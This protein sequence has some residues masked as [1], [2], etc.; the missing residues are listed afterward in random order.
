[1]KIRF[2]LHASANNRIDSSSYRQTK[3]QTVS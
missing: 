2:S 3:Q 1:V